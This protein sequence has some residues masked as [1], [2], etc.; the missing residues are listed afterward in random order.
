MRK[1]FDI[2]FDRLREKSVDTNILCAPFWR[3]VMKIKDS[4]SE[5]DAWS[6]LTDNIEW[7]I[8]MEVFSTKELIDWFKEEE[9]NEHGIYFQGDVLC[10]NST[11]IGL[12]TCN[13]KAT[14]HSRV[15]L[16]DTAMAK[17]DDTTFIS[18][19]HQSKIDITDC[20]G[21]G[22]HDSMATVG[23]YAKFEAWGNSQVNAKNYSYVILHENAKCDFTKNVHVLRQ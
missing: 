19:Y 3:R 12:G 4:F 22:F 1:V 10:N 16:F 5:E 8:N 13:I 2:V 17:G 14:G 23:G 21:Q 20:S 15:I 6:M 11:C 9:L 18:A 7:L